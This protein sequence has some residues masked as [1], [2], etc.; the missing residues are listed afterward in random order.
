MKKG[1]VHS[2]QWLPRA[3]LS[4]WVEIVSA[5]ILDKTMAHF[6]NTL[7]ANVIVS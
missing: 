1:F 5:S 6:Y 3:P 4:R 2:L 7:R